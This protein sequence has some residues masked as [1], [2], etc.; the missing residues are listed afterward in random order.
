VKEKTLIGRLLRSRML[1]LLVFAAVVCCV[2]FFALRG[3]SSS[4]DS[5]QAKFVE[6][7]VRRSAVQCYAIEGSFPDTIGGLQYLESNYGL[8]IDY[9]RYAVYYQSMG[10]NLI[11]EVRV[12]PI[13]GG[14]EIQSLF[15]GAGS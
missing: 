2:V 15:Y 5:N 10:G 13:T 6:D 9:S 14:N 11:P 8:T 12:I 3:V 1:W 4:V 7:S